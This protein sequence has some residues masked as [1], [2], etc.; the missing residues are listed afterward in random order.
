[1]PLFIRTEQAITTFAEVFI[2]H[3]IEYE[4][5]TRNVAKFLTN[6]MASFLKKRKMKIQD[7]DNMFTLNLRFLLLSKTKKEM[8]HGEV[9]K[10]VEKLLD[11]EEVWIGEKDVAD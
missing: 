10:I 11:N 7:L 1:M 8:T 2:G 5:F 3:G 4:G 6:E 9:K